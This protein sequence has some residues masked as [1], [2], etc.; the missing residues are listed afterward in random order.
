MLLPHLVASYPRS[1]YKL[2]EIR[3]DSEVQLFFST[4]RRILP[5]FINL[6]SICIARSKVERRPFYR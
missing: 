3:R 4:R 6:D 2:T 1:E 5:F